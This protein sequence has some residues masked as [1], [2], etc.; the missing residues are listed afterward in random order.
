[1][2]QDNVRFNISSLNRGNYIF[3]KTK[4]RAILT[5]DDL[6]DVINEPKPVEPDETW[7]RRN[8]KTMACITLTVED[9]QLIHFT[10]LDNAFD[11]WQALLRKYERSTFGSRL[12]LRRNISIHY[13]GGPMSNH[14]DA[15]MEVV[16]LLRGSR[17]PHEDEKIVVV[18]LVSL[19]ESYSGLVMAVRD[20]MRS[21]NIEIV[22]GKML[23]EY[24]R[25]I[26]SCKSEKNS[27]VALLL[28]SATTVLS[29]G[30]DNNHT[31][32]EKIRRNVKEDN[33]K[34]QICFFYSKSGHIK[35]ES[36]SY[37]KFQQRKKTSTEVKSKSSS[38]SWR[39][40]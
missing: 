14:I 13:R 20:E 15:I 19:P 9:S 16:G 36:R 25:H 37:K 21:F 27:E 24:Q 26:E 4:V 31:K 6:W 38:Q 39:T 8:N 11:V 33:K 2:T 1:M 35:A 17:K 23:D 32:N 5:R 34:T 3:W 22:T 12:Y 18:L 40:R 30:S 29:K 10:H 28:K 7:K